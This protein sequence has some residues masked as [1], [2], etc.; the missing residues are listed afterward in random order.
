[1]AITNGY[2]T[3]AELKE[4]LNTGGMPTKYTPEDERNLEFAIEAMSRLVDEQFSTTFYARTETRYFSSDFSDLLYIDD[5][6]S[7]TTLK[8]DADGDATY[9]DTWATSDYWLEPRNART[10]ADAEQMKPYRQ[11]RVNP[12]GDYTFPCRRYDVEIVGS[13]GYTTAPPPVVK[14]AM[15]LMSNRIYRRK[16]AIF[17]IA[18]TPAL[19]VMT[20]RARIQEDTD[21]QHLLSGID[22]R[23]W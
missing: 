13:W 17:G 7:V 11:I 6:I 5:L 12:E 10:N 19:G 8:T 4:H 3:L 22:M 18:G 16:D 1:M 14:E 21:I 2:L 15:L 9:E 23:G 20:V